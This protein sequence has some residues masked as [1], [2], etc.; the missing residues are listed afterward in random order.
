[1]PHGVAAN[2]GNP[3]FPTGFN[4]CRTC[5]GSNLDNPI[6]D[7]VPSCTGCHASHGFA[8]W[9]TNCTFCHGNFGGGL[10]TDAAPPRDILGNTAASSKHVGAHQAHLFGDAT[11]SPKISNGVACTDCHGGTTGTLPTSFE[12]HANGTIEV[13]PKQPSLEPSFAGTPTGSYDST[14]GTCSS[15]YCHGNLLHNGKPNNSVS[16]TATSVSGCDACHAP[17]YW[18]AHSLTTETEGHQVHNSGCALCHAAEV[19]RNDCAQCHPGYSRPGVSG[20]VNAST[21]VNGKVE[22]VGGTFPI[23]W[24]PVAR[25]CTTACH[26]VT[27][28]KNNGAPQTPTIWRAP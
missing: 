3:A 25:T 10:Q 2:Y 15:V 23:T 7:T 26:A 4:G 27:T 21:H 9:A 16:W 6:A 28:H 1:V 5:H 8:N 11:N 18:T 22:V 13:T 19:S 14:T 17:Q 20:T 24:D 12:D